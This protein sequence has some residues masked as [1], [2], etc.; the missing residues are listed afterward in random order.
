MKLTIH[1]L[2]GLNE[3]K[4][5]TL[6]AG[7]NKTHTQITNIM[8]M[9]AAD[10]ER[11]MIPGQLLL[12][13]LYGFKDFTHEQLEPFVTKVVSG[14]GS[15]IIVKTGRLV[16]HVPETLIQLCETHQVPL[17]EIPSKT[18]YNDI[19]VAVMQILFHEKV[20]LLDYYYQTHHKFM[21]L[22]LTNLHFDTILKLLE[23]TVNKPVVLLYD[24]TVRYA[25]DDQWIGGTPQQSLPFAGET[26][27]PF[28]RSLYYFSQQT[29]TFPVIE[30]HVLSDEF[31]SY[32]LQI[33]EI[34]TITEAF[35]FIAIENAIHYI[36]MC[37]IQENTIREV[38]HSL[39]NDLID[40]LILGRSDS[41]IFIDHAL[42]HLNMDRHAQYR[43]VFVR[44][45]QTPTLSTK[46]VH[47]RFITFMKRQFSGITYRTRINRIIFIIP[48]QAAAG[49]NA[50]QFKNRFTQLLKQFTATQ[51][52]PI[53][54]QACISDLCWLPDFKQQTER[55]YQNLE[56]AA[57]VLQEQSYCIIN[58]DMM[59]YHFLDELTQKHGVGLIVPEDLVQLAQNKPELFH[60]LEVYL[61]HNQNIKD[62]AA[63][64]FVHPKTIAYRLNSIVSQ[65]AIDFHDF[66]STLRYTLAVKL[67][68]VTQSPHQQSADDT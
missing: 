2:L 12:T 52:Q 62:S 54:F 9:E 53:H 4:N 10:L 64:L 1:Q 21:Q 56:L 35:N 29:A 19:I 34:D 36:K 48:K 42:A 14:K 17:I 6:L 13:S 47:Q 63:A 51:P 50:H 3:M 27:F 65:T 38:T 44:F 5:A 30:T 28:T 37:I 8:V 43:I 25:T 59:V 61:T 46:V 40:D 33:I 22:A 11:W 45:S 15:G 26:I 7:H 60:T 49:D 16:E 67:L 32:R 58:D 57:K 20:A 55:A 23:Q 18:Q 66:E 31:G 68:K 41:T 24:N 39:K